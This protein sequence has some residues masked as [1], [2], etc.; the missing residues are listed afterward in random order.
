MVKIRVEWILMSPQF[1][2]S[3]IQGFYS[4][5]TRT[6]LKHAAIPAVSIE[7]VEVEYPHMEVSL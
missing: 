1:K 6:M 3:I 2:V 7:N 5:Y 4:G